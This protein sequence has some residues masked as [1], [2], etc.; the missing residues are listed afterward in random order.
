MTYVI[1]DPPY[2]EAISYGD[3]SDFFYV[4]LRLV[5]AGHS[6]HFETQV[7]DKSREI[8]QHDPSRQRQDGGSQ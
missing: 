7:T 3:L 1:T 8:V 4:W 6:E 2:Y 5:L